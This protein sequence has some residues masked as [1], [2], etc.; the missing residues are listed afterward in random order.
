[1]T[2]TQ[3]KYIVA[4]DN[5]RHFAKAAEACFVT[6]PTLSMQ[7]QKLEEELDILIFDRSKHPIVPTP[8][9]VRLIEQARKILHES[10]VLENMAK[11][12]KG[13]YE[14]T[15]SLGVIPTVA[16]SLLPRFIP[17]FK[18]KFPNITLKIE[19]LK[20]EGLPLTLRKAIP[21]LTA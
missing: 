3:F 20:T 15:L 14:G 10:A 12:I 6:Q 2:I 17:E 13:S 5:H 7:I 4:V 11:R 21:C 18:S 16:P 1:M 19:E 8:L 9:G